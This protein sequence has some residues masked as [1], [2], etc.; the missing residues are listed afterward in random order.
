M[1]MIIA[2]ALGLFAGAYLW[3]QKFKEKADGFIK[4]AADKNKNKSEDQKK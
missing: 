2:F 4:K 3:N 1:E